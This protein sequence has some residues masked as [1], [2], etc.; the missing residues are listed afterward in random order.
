VR[1]EVVQPRFRPLIAHSIRPMT[2][3]IL[4]KSSIEEL[5]LERITVTTHLTHNKAAG[6]PKSPN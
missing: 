5:T 6:K 3:P 4:A 2:T 1:L